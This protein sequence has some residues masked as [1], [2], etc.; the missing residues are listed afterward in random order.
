LTD[1]STLLLSRSDIASL[2]TLD[3]CI[4]VVQAAFRAHANGHALAPTLMHVD[5]V[6]GEFHVKAG[7]LIFGHRSYFA[8]KANGGFFSNT[9]RHGLPNI[10]GIIYLAD[11]SNGLPLAIMESGGIT[12]LRTGAATAVA[13]KFLARDDAQVAT[14]CGAGRQ[15]RIQLQ[16]LC[17]VL[18]LTTAFI[19]SRDAARAQETARELSA[20]LGITVRPVTSLSASVENSDVVVTCTPS[21]KPILQK[22][23]ISPGTFIAAVGAD[24][25]EKQELDPEILRDS[26]V[27]TDITEQ[28]MH[29]GE[30]HHALEN[31]IMTLNDVRGELGEIITGRAV[32]RSS[33]NEIT[34]FDSTGTALQDTAAAALVYEKAATIGRGLPMNF[35]Q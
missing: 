33:R 34:I 10:L 26:V 18:P 2:L 13:A 23:W 3:E 7:G 14:I 15:A 22:S 24:S 35:S 29:V 27:V 5:A 19:W 11:A 4:S 25:P 28:C 31:G 8:L 1:S 9:E 17:K 30:L 12:A 20:E 6:D 16:A 21:R 32:G